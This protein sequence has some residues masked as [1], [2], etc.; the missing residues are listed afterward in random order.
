MA[1]MFE[2]MTDRARKVLVLSMEE[3]R[4]FNH[5]HI[6]TE[7]LLLGLISEGEGVAASAL[8]S[9]DVSLD[10]ARRRVEQYVKVGPWPSP[11]HIPFTPRA[12]KVLELSLREALEL[13][14]SYIG[15]EHLLLGL[16]RE[17]PGIGARVIVALDVPLERVRAEVLRLLEGYSEQLDEPPLSEPLCAG[18]RARVQHHVRWREV[19]AVGPDETERA[20]LIFYCG[21]CGTTLNAI[22]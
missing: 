9:F 10:K 11:G 22:N 8:A 2:R 7:H 3:A 18:C 6:G 19:R 12:K 14:H 21:A 5:A 15:T 20:V 16:L 17:G 13:G 1:T 4:L